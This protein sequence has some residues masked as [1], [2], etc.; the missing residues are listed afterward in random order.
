MKGLQGLFDS[1]GDPKKS[2][3][4]ILSGWKRTFSHGIPSMS[5]V[6]VSSSEWRKGPMLMFCIMWIL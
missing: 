4:L 3:F 1:Q 5:D 2:V 6:K